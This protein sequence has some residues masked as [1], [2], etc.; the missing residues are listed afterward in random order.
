[1]AVQ[2]LSKVAR[3]LNVGI[4]TIVD[5]LETKGVTIDAK[6]NTKL[7]ADVY[8]IVSQEF[9]S[10]KGAKEESKNV[11]MPSTDRESV[12]IASSIASAE[13]TPAAEPE[14][15]SILIKNIPADEIVEESPK[16]P[17]KQEAV[18]PKVVAQEV[19]TPKAV[20]QETI[21]PKAPSVQVE[22]L[23]AGNIGDDGKVKVLGKIDL[24]SMNLK[25]RPDKKSKKEQE[26]EAKAE[27]IAKVIGEK[28]RKAADKEAGKVA[29]AK[30]KEDEIAAAKTAAEDA[31]T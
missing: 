6:P 1:M 11:S 20:V 10:D 2:R 30:K 29:A 24:S 8:D 23:P 5:F 31:E 25:T 26:A 4:S 13:K 15:E 27:K 3:E 22:I 9:A 7:D 21:A 19:V 12:S 18:I 28:A 14:D 16:P 17:V